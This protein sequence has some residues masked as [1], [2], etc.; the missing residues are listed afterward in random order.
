VRTT[1]QIP[2][3]ISKV[4]FLILILGVFSTQFLAQTCPETCNNL[5]VSIEL[6]S[7]T[8][9]I[10]DFAATAN[11]YESDGV[12]YT[13]EYTWFL[14]SFDQ[15]DAEFISLN[16][17]D[18]LNGN[19]LSIVTTVYQDGTLMPGC[20]CDTALDL[21]AEFADYELIC[22]CSL[23]MAPSASF[24]VVEEGI[25]GNEGVEFITTSSGVGL[26]YDW[27]F[28]DGY[29][30]G[31]SDL[32]SPVVEIIING[33]SSTEVPIILTVTDLYG[34]TD[35]A[36]D[37]ITILETPNPGY[38][39]IAAICSP[40]PNDLTQDLTLTPE[41]ISNS[42]IEEIT[43]EWGVGEP[44]IIVPT[45]WSFDLES[46]SYSSF[47][48]YLIS[49]ESL[50]L[51]GCM[52]L[53]SDSIFI[54][55]N[56][57]IGTANPGNTNGLCS[58]Y[59]LTFP[60]SNFEANSDETIYYVD[61]GDGSPELEFNHPPP[62]EISHNFTTSSCGFT[63]PEGSQNAY[64]FRVIASNE[65]SQ[66]VTTVDPIRIHLSP[67]PD[68]IGLNTACVN[69]PF[70]YSSPS[71][72]VF[73]E[74]NAPC[75][76]TS[77][78][79][80]VIPLEGQ[81]NAIPPFGIGGYITTIYQEAGLYNIHVL[82]E[83]E[84]CDDG[85]DQIQVCV[86]PQLNPEASFFP[87]N[88]C[89]PLTVQLNDIT[90]ALPCGTANHHWEITGG[91]Y[92]WQSGSS[93]EDYNPSVVFLDEGVY[94]VELHH[95]V[96]G[97]AVCPEVIEYFDIEVYDVPIIAIET[98]GT[99]CEGESWS[100]D[101][102]NISDGSDPSVNFSWFLD[103]TLYSSDPASIIIPLST[104]GIYNVLAEISNTC[105]TDSD[106]ITI[107][108]EPNPVLE[109]V[110]PQG[111]C[112]GEEVEIIVSGAEGFSWSVLDGS[113][114]SNTTPDTTQLLLNTS[115][116]G[117]ITGFIY[118]AETTC[119]TTTD[120]IIEAYTIPQI[121]LSGL[122]TICYDN[123]ISIQAN[124]SSGSPDYV[125][126]WT[127]TSDVIGDQYYFEIIAEVNIDI[128]AE[129]LDLN[130][131]ENSQVISI[132][133]LDLPEVYAGSDIQLCDQP[134]LIT[135]DENTPTGGTW[136]GAGIINSNLGVYDPSILGVGSA[137]VT[138]QYTDP[139]GCTNSDFLTIDIFSPEEAAVGLDVFSCNIDSVIALTGYSPLGGS[140]QGVNVSA[141]EPYS[142]N[143]Q[144]MS[145]GV[146]SYTYN[147]GFETCATSDV[148][149]LEIYENPSVVVSPNVTY[150]C[151][152]SEVILS[153]NVSGG[154]VQTSSDYDIYWVGDLEIN[155]LTPWLATWDASSEDLPFI[156]SVSDL[157]GCSSTSQLTF[158]VLDL[159]VITMPLSL[160]ECN[161][162]FVVTLPSPEPS[163]GVWTGSGIINGSIGT[164]D[165][166]LLEIGFSSLQYD[167]TDNFGC[168]NFSTT[169]IEL[170]PPVFADAG[171][172][173]SLCDVDSILLLEGFTPATDGNWVGNNVLN[174]AIGQ[175]DISPLTPG[176]YNYIYEYGTGSCF[177]E[178][179]LEIEVF[180]RPTITWMVPA[181][182]CLGELVELEVMVAGGLAPYIIDWISPLAFTSPDGYSASNTWWLAGVYQLEILV[183]DSRGCVKT[184]T[185][186]LTIH[187][188][189]TV[190]AG[191]D[192][193]F[194]DQP[195]V[196]VFEGFSPGLNELGIGYFSGL[197]GALTAVTQAGEYTPT[198]SGS[199]VFEVVY[200][201]TSSVTTCVNFDT[202][203]VVI[204]APDVAFAGLDTI[205][206]NNAPQIQLTGFT[207]DV[208]SFWSGFGPQANGALIDNQLGII[209]PQLLQPGS[210]Q[211]ILEYGYGTCYTS[212]ILVLEI[213]PL[214]IISLQSNDE[215]CANNGEVN[216]TAFSPIGGTWE[217]V[218]VVD[219]TEG[220]FDVSVGVGQWD[221]LYSYTDLLTTCTDTALHQVLVQDIPAVFA[222]LD[223]IFCNQPL[224][225][226]F[227]GNSPGVN[228]GGDG[229][230]YGIGASELAVNPLGE[231]NPSITGPGSFSVIYTFTD[232]FTQCINSDTLQVI[233]AEPIEAYAGIDT[234]ACNNAPQILLLNYSP[235]IGVNWLGNGV[236]AEASLLNSQQ[237]IIDPQLLSPGAHQFTIEYG[238]GTCYTSDNITVSIDALPEINL[239]ASEQYCHNLGEQMLNSATPFGGYWFGTNIIDAGSG[240]FDTSLPEGN[241][242]VEYTYT[243][244]GTQ[245]ADTLSHQITILPVPQAIFSADNLGCNNSPYPI[246]QSSV[247]ATFFDWDFGDGQESQIA[248]PNHQYDDI[249]IY[250]VVLYASNDW[251]CI[252]TTET[253]IE[254]TDP[255]IAEFLLSETSGCAPLEIAISNLSY[256]PY[257]TFL[258]DLNGL[259]TSDTIPPI[260]EFLQ[261][262]S[263]VEYEVVLT[264]SNLCG[265][266]IYTDEI[267]VFPQPQ[268]SFAILNDT[269]CSPYTA[270]MIYTG[271]GLPDELIWDF[272]N[273]ETGEGIVPD[274][275]TYLVDTLTT[276]F[277]I[278]LLAENDCGA[279][280]FSS[281][282][283]VQP[284][285][286]T[287]FF[288]MNTTAGCPPLQINVSDLSIS[289]TNVTYDFGDGNYSSETDATNIYTEEGVYEIIQYVTNGC[290][291]D[292]TSVEIVIHPEPVISIFANDN[293]FCEG[294]EAFFNVESTDPGLISWDFGDGL[295]GVGVDESHIY[296]N[297]GFY[298]ATATVLSNLFGCEA[299]ETIALEV[300]ATPDLNITPD[301]LDGCSPLDVSFVNNS[302][303]SD[304]WLWDFGD[305][306]P[307]TITSSPVHTFINT[308]SSLV[309]HE[310]LVMGSTIN[311][312]E[313]STT[314]TISVSP[315]PISAFE[316][317]DLLYC[318]IPNF[319]QTANLSEGA[320]SFN[321]NLN[322]ALLGAQF[323]PELNVNQF[324]EHIVELTAFNSYGCYASSI[325]TFTV[326][327]Y[328]TPQVA[329][330]PATGCEPI[331][332]EFTNLTIG[333]FSSNLSIAN[334]D[335]VVY[336][337]IFPVEQVLFEHAGNYM[338]HLT[339]ISPE[340]CVIDYDVFNVVEVW[341]LPNADFD[342]QPL[343]GLPGDL[344]TSNLLNTGVTF[345]N[346]SSGD[347]SSEWTFGDGGI[348]FL[349]S[350][351]HDFMIAG[352]YPVNLIVTSTDGCVSS[353]MEI[354][355]IKAD[356]EIYV[357][358]AFTP[359]YIGFGGN[360]IND[361]FRAEFSDLAL[362]ESFNFRIFNRGGELI[363][364]T[365]DPEE[366]WIGE[367]GVEGEYYVPNAVYVWQMEIR[368]TVW[369]DIAKE[370]RGYVTIIR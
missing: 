95:S 306:T 184:S 337:G 33:G 273:G 29:L 98:S 248:S 141:I 62:L 31:Q 67:A 158:D 187:D 91:A 81:T 168:S 32:S 114:Q 44:T 5:N 131:C 161:Q 342:A 24:T 108:V 228:Q 86:Y 316:I 94:T 214:P 327:E 97:L 46:P 17:E 359:P 268:M 129:V 222:G 302:S 289:T 301:L 124:V 293:I 6:L 90:P 241:Y 348:S 369:G 204:A 319:A 325:E 296:L 368:S 355:S 146:Y 13:T 349:D 333:A 324:G 71:S 196:G 157:L 35:Q 126:N 16:I 353:H 181:E 127:P 335:W 54:G 238:I 317:E 276:E 245:C 360:G 285:T 188:L 269:V 82:E 139:E 303:D 7:D 345:D 286:V 261:G 77:G 148:I 79:W 116:T 89:L 308:T 105:G 194:C 28:G 133:V 259:L 288:Q 9:C 263:I 1:S 162:S 224:L 322:F 164:F 20:I 265:T 232:N 119:S 370:L 221:L 57:Q 3:F 78:I 136:L 362:I 300:T 361:A 243:D 215:F 202:L 279:D 193:T 152:G 60:I 197:G 206:C 23:E 182:A 149:Q 111:A 128:I 350:P 203:Q 240:L 117:S 209:D 50:A 260:Q 272:G 69:V 310:V 244:P 223:T 284:N 179:N 134:I 274:P 363:W 195:I 264:V 145:P 236:E 200:T 122:S 239:G 178:D 74:S 171:I 25:C 183:T 41:P 201:F 287:A 229:Y 313:A 58:P 151:D 147:Y 167:Y 198:V 205:V 21:Q 311:G 12:E 267:S 347:V 252:D 56:P 338:I 329:F 159:P 211:Y 154:E 290:S 156:I 225:G 55:T 143:I 281:T 328:P 48:Y 30:Y 18:V 88:G 294:E 118:Y 102:S 266:D 227:E 249:G 242:N 297:S 270:E 112:T 275:P 364:E 189:P 53:I 256:F 231:F 10:I 212:D 220:T 351:S 130:G 173:I 142:I 4:I 38:T 191:L 175:I 101:I 163:G 254:V 282:I 305:S 87:S 246:L 283:L 230:F 113:T 26:N 104:S 61:F 121:S 295:T 160:L 109:V 49:I 72:G 292:T 110:Y 334:S 192:T 341:P 52:S 135:L 165:P 76:S 309:Q 15:G 336:E 66:S 176:V 346:M 34:C 344:F 257:S 27:S 68:I 103:E 307:A 210:H 39:G 80:S 219:E 218:G 36:F 100:V 207:P 137:I 106:E 253:T 144:G 14:D 22:E 43:I 312:C 153:A 132:D 354:I 59:T 170:I 2:S 271:V 96:P 339:A 180:E 172:D 37:T 217:G 315:E 321:W 120:F 365:H 174:P 64:R 262:D 92:E 226:F 314:F 366:Y 367:V 185:I 140:W 169:E 258:W 65:C 251:G 45:D 213:D 323:E 250:D 208:G 278:T 190:F 85:E 40:D 247:G 19:I 332:V 155:P 75:D 277:T 234:T 326:Y 357:P 63:T 125:V 352:D 70:S 299:I 73:A 47:G 343:I 235:D 291:Y 166:G 107:V 199:G 93:F 83:H 8:T 138:Y 177:T 298:T 99:I 42:G 331:L 51:N 358:N 340:G 150:I 320:V 11:E 356:L 330:S 216:L 255:P 233:V 115:V 318:G 186:E 304:F 123:T 280:S 84:S 237:G